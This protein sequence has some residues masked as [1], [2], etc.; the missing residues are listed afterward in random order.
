MAG[1][2]PSYRTVVLQDDSL[3]SLGG[4]T[5]VPNVVLKH[6]AISFGAKVAYGVL[7][8]YAWSDDFCFPAQERLAKD[9]DCSVRQVQRL[10]NELKDHSFITWKQQGLNKPNIY[11]LLPMSRWNRSDSSTNPDTTNMSSPD[12]TDTAPQDATKTS[13]KEDS[14]KNT[15]T[16]VNRR[17]NDHRN[18]VRDRPAA[19]REASISDPALRSTYQLSD[20][21][22]G[23]VHWLVERQVEILGSAERNHSHYV[24]R[25]AEAVKAGN[26]PVLDRLLGEFKQAAATIAVASRPAYFHRMYQE[27]LE[28]YQTE[29]E[30]KSAAT[31]PPGDHHRGPQAGADLFRPPENDQPNDPRAR[32]IADAEGR[33]FSVPD[34]IRTAD[35]SAVNHWWAGLIDSAPSA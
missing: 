1:G 26:D 7:L 29:T 12:T 31:P 17:A 16:V 8:S 18:P 30:P 2:A 27:A 9:L 13:Y 25:A 22:I 15:H 24:K 32:I 14:M 20:D 35:L 11:Y 34:Y 33:G 6:P 3:R 21:Q 4:F 23:R 10:L 28:K 19:G 5:Q